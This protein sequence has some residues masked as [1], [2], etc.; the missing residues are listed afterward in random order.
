VRRQ[1]I[2]HHSTGTA[3]VLTSEIPV[4]AGNRPNRAV[5]LLDKVC[6]AALLT[7]SLPVVIPT[8]LLI[9]VLSKRSPFVAHL[10]VGQFG[11]PLRMLK[12]R[13]MWQAD[14]RSSGPWLVEE[15]GS[16]APESKV[17]G[18]PRVRSRF[19]RW[20]RRYSI[21]ELPQ[22]IHVLR[23]EMS[24]VGPRPITKDE[25]TRHYGEWAEQVVELRPGITG[26]WQTMGRNGLT[27]S[28]RR[29]LD[30]FL[31]RRYSVRLYLRILLR[32]IPRLISGS[33]AW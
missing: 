17:A 11:K 7:V 24:M 2:Q 18:D 19:A 6:A 3:D 23:G 4:L 9:S 28:Q 25:L 31:V 12:L 16:N 27:Y 5:H 8:A 1:L 33:G 15:V 22:L 30:L 26:L 20:C 14:D 10:R 29:R 13:T 21:D 32:T